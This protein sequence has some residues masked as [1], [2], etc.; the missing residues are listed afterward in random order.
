[1]DVS[2]KN[3]GEHI[4]KMNCVRQQPNQA[5]DPYS[6]PLQP[7]EKTPLEIF[8][9]LGLVGCIDGEPDLSINYKPLIHQHLQEKYDRERNS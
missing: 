8:E 1:M 5:I 9:E 3:D 6:Q 7:P 4:G 2:Q